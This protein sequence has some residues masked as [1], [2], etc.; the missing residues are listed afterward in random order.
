MP[1]IERVNPRPG[2][3]EE[4]VLTTRGYELADRRGGGQ[5]NKVINST[6]VRSLEEAADL[7]EKGFSIRMGRPGKRASL[8]SPRSVRI[9]RA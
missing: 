6:F 5:T 3:K 7:I 4:P 1:R 8:I 2:A 9:V